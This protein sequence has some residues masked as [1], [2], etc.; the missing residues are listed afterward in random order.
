MIG[1]VIGKT[2]RGFRSLNLFF[3]KRLKPKFDGTI[4]EKYLYLYAYTNEIATKWHGKYANF[5]S[6]YRKKSILGKALLKPKKIVLRRYYK[7]KRNKECYYRSI[8]GGYQAIISAVKDPNVKNIELHDFAA[9]VT[10]K[11]KLS[12]DYMVRGK[13]LR[14]IEL[15]KEGIRRTLRFTSITTTSLGA[16]LAFLMY[17]PRDT[18]KDIVDFIDNNIYKAEMYIRDKFSDKN[19]GHDEAS[20]EE[21]KGPVKLQA[22]KKSLMEMYKG[23]N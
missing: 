9:Q 16:G 1:K 11:D 21:K 7:H 15:A 8:L 5:L 18:S 20:L 23:I 13:K 4:D 12:E 22:R 3:R 6:K 2:W 19:Q 17:G 14:K 10:S